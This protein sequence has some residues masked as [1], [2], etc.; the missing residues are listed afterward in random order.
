MRSALCAA[1]LVLVAAVGCGSPPPSAERLSDPR[2]IIAGTFASTTAL[3]TVHVALESDIA[4]AA[5]VGG[6]GNTIVEIDLDSTRHAVSA[7]MRA[8]NGQFET[9]VIFVDGVLFNRDTGA[10]G[11]FRSDDGGAV[12]GG[13]DPFSSVPAKADVAKAL[14][15]ALRDPRVDIRLVATESCTGAPCYHVQAQIPAAVLAGLLGNPQAPAGPGDVGMIGDASA[16]AWVDTATLRLLQTRWTIASNPRVTFNIVL[17]RHDE[18]LSITAPPNVEATDAPFSGDLSG[19]VGGDFGPAAGA[20]P[21][22]P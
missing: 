2:Q 22:T 3:R 20:S 12:G 19:D 11:W 5:L 18:P 10:G 17:T 6:M 7:R 15:A 8:P 4:A 9:A 1:V 16:E 14:D 13:S 21:E